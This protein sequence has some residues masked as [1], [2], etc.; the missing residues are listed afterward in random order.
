MRSQCM[1]T[2]FSEKVGAQVKSGQAEGRSS[3]SGH[4]DGCQKGK[5]MKRRKY[6]ILD[7]ENFAMFA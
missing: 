4:A 1:C 6:W 5:M 7:T 3:R 2:S